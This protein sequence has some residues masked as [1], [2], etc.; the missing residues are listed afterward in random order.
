MLIKKI[1][2]NPRLW[3]WLL[4]WLIILEFVG[5]LIIHGLRLKYYDL[6]FAIVLFG[7][8]TT[9]FMAV[10]I[11]KLCLIIKNLQQQINYTK[12]ILQ[13]TQSELNSLFNIDIVGF[14]CI[15]IDGEIKQANDI[16]LQMSGYG[17]EELTSGQISWLEL[18][19]PN[20]TLSNGEFTTKPHR[21]KLLCKDG[22]HLH[23]LCSYKFLPTNQTNIIAYVLDLSERHR[24]KTSRQQD[25]RRIKI[26]RELNNDTTA[27][28]HPK[29]FIQT[30]FAK[31]APELDLDMYWNYM[32]ENNSPVMHLDSHS[33]ISPD[34][35]KSMEYIEI[36]TQEFPKI[37][38][39]NVQHSTEPR[40]V[41][42]RSAG[43]QAYYSQVLRVQGKIFGKIAFAS[44]RRSQFSYKEQAMM[45]AVSSNISIA[46]ERYVLKNFIQQQSEQLR[47]TNRIRDEFLSVLSH[48]LRSPLQSILG[49]SQLLR[50]RNLHT[51][52]VDKGLDAIERNAK[53]QTQIVE[54]LLDISGMIKGKLS[55]NIRNCDLIP[56]LQ[57]VLENVKLATEA[58]GIYFSYCLDGQ[59][60]H[61][62]TSDESTANPNLFTPLN[63]KFLVSGDPERLQQIIWNLLSNAIKFTPH[64]GRV[65]ISLSQVEDVNLPVNDP[66]KF[67]AQIQVK[68]TGI[69]IDSELIPYIFDRFYQT[70][71]SNTRFH[72][73][74]G[75]GLAIAR[76][77]VE[78]HGGTINVASPGIGKGTVFTVKLPLLNIE[79][80]PL[81]Q[82]L[83]ETITSSSDRCSVFYPS[84]GII[85]LSPDFLA[86]VQV[87]I[88]D[89]EVESQD[90]LLAVLQSYQALTQPVSSVIEAMNIIQECKPDVLL[91]NIEMPQEDA[92][93]L[94]RQ[95]RFLE[96][97]EKSRK[98]PAAALTSNSKAE[99]RMR[100]IH[101]GYQM[102]L[103]KPV[104]PYELVTVVGCLAGRI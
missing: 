5:W 11:G 64:G 95:I 101:E 10:L 28:S 104:E 50:S 79:Y 14:L 59:H 56:I 85:N 66:W 74:M 86:D 80:K 98:T 68:D 92:Y 41:L 15:N 27:Y 25:Q 33:G 83:N 35:A 9:A 70:D 54:D 29:L 99:Q 46:M 53:L 22:S 36:V 24:S 93:S 94:I 58:K 39:K 90:F 102:Y 17:R 4:L 26:L 6:E 42:L 88:F 100:A 8:G 82:K 87:L 20:F 49:W 76:H 57:A 51:T 69:G 89:S 65:D 103:F 13:K 73:G 21:Q 30:W 60:K 12:E 37:V 62:C 3:L 63:S 18:L 31:L 61:Q 78:L 40:T 67:Y 38:L 52:Q 96:N 23:V 47:D 43:V 91:C 72:G 34:L 71:S 44:R 81:E 19:S 16:L 32:V 97:T 2:G 84:T 7:L 55:L 75:L 77:L 48:E 45:E 1:P